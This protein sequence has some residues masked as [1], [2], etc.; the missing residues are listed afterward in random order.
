MVN[1]DDFPQQ[2]TGNMPGERNSGGKQRG[3]SHRR[4]NRR[5][6]PFLKERGLTPKQ[7]KF[8]FHYAKGNTIE[9][10]ATDAGIA[11]N[12]ATRWLGVAH[13]QKEIERQTELLVR[14]LITRAT[15][16]SEQ[17]FEKLFDI[18]MNDRNSNQYK[19]LAKLWDT[20]TASIIP[21]LSPV[22]QHQS[23]IDAPGEETV[24][25][26]DEAAEILESLFGQEVEEDEIIEGAAR[27][28]SDNTAKP[29]ESIRDHGYTDSIWA[30]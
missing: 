25:V 20:M 24:E 17:V 8:A 30:K 29:S 1:M 13:V 28:I 5:G 16:A 6:R 3:N 7:K 23:S 22:Q 12:T 18:A 14:G 19:A 2:K 10:S 21:R 4:F 27:E 11:Y 9:Q 26:G 15:G